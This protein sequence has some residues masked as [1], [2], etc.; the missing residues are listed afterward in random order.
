MDKKKPVIF[1]L[2]E[3]DLE[4]EL[5]KDNFTKLTQ[6]QGIKPPFLNTG[7]VSGT[8]LTPEGFNAMSIYSNASDEDLLKILFANLNKPK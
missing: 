8:T 1:P 3:D 5:L 4:E 6:T 2:V 7:K